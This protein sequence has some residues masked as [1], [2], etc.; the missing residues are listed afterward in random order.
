MLLTS[1]ASLA[2]NPQVELTTNQGRIVLELDQKNAPKTVANFLQYV[3]NKHYDGLIFHRIIN[4][5]MIQGG[6]FTPNIQEKPTLAP[7]TNEADNGLKN[8]AYTI[9]MARTSN[10][11]SATS[12]FFI[13]VN[14]NDFLNLVN[15]SINVQ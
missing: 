1:L 7:I 11:Y 15:L 14:N 8:D 9:A 12:Q 4:G 13:N 6:G 10:P 5:F 3:N 2:A